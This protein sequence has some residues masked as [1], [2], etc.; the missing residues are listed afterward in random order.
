[1]D[2]YNYFGFIVDVEYEVFFMLLG[3]WK[4]NVF[5]FGI[6]FENFDDV[7]VLVVEVFV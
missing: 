5:Y 6:R 2:F 4:K 1:M 3:G 7:V